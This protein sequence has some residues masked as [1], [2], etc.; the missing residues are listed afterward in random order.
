MN[1][2]ADV[3][4]EPD[5][6]IKYSKVLQVHELSLF[7]QRWVWEGIIAESLIFINAD[8]NN[9]ADGE[10]LAL[11]K[12]SGP[13]QENSTSTITRNSSGY[14]FVNCNFENPI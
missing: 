14:T 3:P 5:T 8:L 10:L 4:V 12:Q 2:F 11:V 1:K 6:I 9:K 7:H 13:I